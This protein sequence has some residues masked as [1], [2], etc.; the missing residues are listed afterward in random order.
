M[1]PPLL[2]TT[3]VVACRDDFI[4]ANVDG[5]VIALGV[6][7]GICYGMNQVCSRIWNMI[8]KP[9]QIRDLCATLVS[10]YQVDAD[11]CERQV[12][13]LLE[14]LRAEGLIATINEK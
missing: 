14:E 2:P 7:Q 4:E 11:V 5:E 8:A 10:M 12:V 6:E 1:Y 9:I 13:D 3:K